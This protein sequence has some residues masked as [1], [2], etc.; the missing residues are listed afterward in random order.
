MKFKFEY[1]FEYVE[2][3]ELEP[4]SQSFVMWSGAKTKPVGAC[5]LPVENPRNSK[6]YKVRFLVVE[7]DLTPLL[8]FNAMEKTGLLTV[9][10]GNFV[11]VV[12][13]L[14]SNFAVKNADV[15]MGA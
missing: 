11:S 6:K 2:D 7:E 4:C 13:S 9:D 12:E 8:G 14:E 15:L 10:K 1:V 3:M 5:A